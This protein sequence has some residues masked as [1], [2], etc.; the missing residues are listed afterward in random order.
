LL[1]I[2]FEDVIRSESTK[3]EVRR[4]IEHSILIWVSHTFGPELLRLNV[5]ND[6]LPHSIVSLDPVHTLVAFALL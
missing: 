3:A 4:P 2:L 5:L 1:G 6:V